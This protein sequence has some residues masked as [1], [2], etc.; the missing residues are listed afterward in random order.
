MGTT[1]IGTPSSKPCWDVWLREGKLLLTEELIDQIWGSN[2][3]SNRAVH[4]AYLHLQ[5]ASV[6]SPE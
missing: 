4:S 6:W 5:A 1:W 2:P 3:P